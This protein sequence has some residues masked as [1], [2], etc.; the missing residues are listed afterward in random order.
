M[1]IVSKLTV[2]W[3]LTTVNFQTFVF[4][5]LVELLLACSTFA[6]ALAVAVALFA[7]YAFALISIVLAMRYAKW[8]DAEYGSEYAPTTT[9]AAPEYGRR[10][11]PS[12]ATMCTCQ[13][14]VDAP[15]LPPLRTTAMMASSPLSSEAAARGCCGL[16]RRVDVGS[17]LVLALAHEWISFCIQPALISIRFCNM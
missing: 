8:L 14:V 1:I 9:A 7:I 17:I 5:L 6:Y 11:P 12:A 4:L 15:L 2:V 3:K 16:V 10:L 13:R